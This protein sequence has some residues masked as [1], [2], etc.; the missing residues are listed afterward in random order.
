MSSFHFTDAEQPEQQ[1]FTDVGKLN[2]FSAEQLSEFVS[3]VLSFLH[4][5]GAGGGADANEALEAFSEEH[6]VNLKALR[7][8]I[9]GV[10]F[11]FA[12]ALKKNL[13]PAHIKEDLVKLGLKEDSAEVLAA[14]WKRKF[15]S[16]SSSMIGKT[17]SVNQLVDM[18]WKFGVTVATDELSS[19]GACHLQ[20]KLVIDRGNKRRENVVMEMTLPQFYEFFH[21]MQAA[22]RQ[23]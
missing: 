8:I 9:R 16:M 4:G 17:L 11:F 21:Q 7:G 20:L 13:S 10:L 1:L 6:G 3:I 18:E 22:S 15:A 2:G 12:E 23:M 19:V 14:Q 5:G